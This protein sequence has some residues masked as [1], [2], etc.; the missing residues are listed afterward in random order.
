MFPCSHKHTHKTPH[1]KKHPF[2]SLKKPQ[3]S[4]LIH[5]TY[6]LDVASTGRIK[7]IWNPRLNHS[8]LHKSLFRSLCPLLMLTLCQSHVGC[9]QGLLYDPSGMYQAD[10]HVLLLNT[11][12]CVIIKCHKI[13]YIHLKKGQER[14]LSRKK[15]SPE[16]VGDLGYKK[17]R[18]YYARDLLLK[19]R[20]STERFPKRKPSRKASLKIKSRKTVV[21]YST[22]YR[23]KT[24]EFMQL[25][26]PTLL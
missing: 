3:T 18:N 25:A 10:K 6:G 1:Y 26:N 7:L 4:E 11:N 24:H 15:P 16:H 20:W 21:H 14:A 17:F 13:I 23:N 8:D 12:S 9:A 19:L 5:F 2:T 22:N